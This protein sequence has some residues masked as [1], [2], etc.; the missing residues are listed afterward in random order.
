MLNFCQGARTLE[1]S[2]LLHPIERS[3]GGVVPV[4]VARGVVP[5]AVKTTAVNTVVR[6]TTNKPEE[7]YQEPMSNDVDY[8]IYRIPILSVITGNAFP[9]YPFRKDYFKKGRAEQCQDEAPE[10]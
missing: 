3:E 1:N 10:V 4:R 7:C 2:I 8:S 9:V 5:V 6:V